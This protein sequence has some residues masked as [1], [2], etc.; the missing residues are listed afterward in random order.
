M[1]EFQEKIWNALKKIPKGK[2]STYKET[3]KA[4]GK[5]KSKKT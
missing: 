5:P 2:I 3:A 4:I 1:T